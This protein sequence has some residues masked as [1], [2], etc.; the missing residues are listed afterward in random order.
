MALDIFLLIVVIVGTF[1]LLA[2]NT[3]LLA[4]WQH[5]DDQNTA[6]LP[7]IV[8]I[9]GFTFAE[10]AVLLL[11]LDV[12]N[13][14]GVVGCDTWNPVCGGIDMSTLWSIIFIVI[15]N[16]RECQRVFHLLTLL[17]PACLLSYCIF[18]G[19]FVLVI[20]PYS[21]FYYEADDGGVGQNKTP[22]CVTALRYELGLLFISLLILV[23]LFVFIGTTEV[24]YTELALKA[25]DMT[26]TLAVS[27]N[28]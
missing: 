20:I 11:P 27:V 22:L 13:M 23:L 28:F 24:P 2:S 14:T 6:Y 3:Y 18:S 12:A 9:L 16:S 8:I 19:I 25:T 1:I 26:S 7:K 15:G 21:M 4:Y 10:A 5:P 17:L